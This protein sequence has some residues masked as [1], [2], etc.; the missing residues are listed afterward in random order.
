MPLESSLTDLEREQARLREEIE[1]LKQEY[2]SL[3]QQQSGQNRDG[4]KKEQGDVKPDGDKQD[5]DKKQEPPKPPLRTR[6]RSWVQ[7]HPL[8]TAALAVAFVA[9]LIGAFVFWRYLSSYESTDDAEVDGHTDELSSRIAGVVVGVYVENAQSVHAGQVLVDLDPSDYRVALAQA[10]ANLSAAVTGA[11]QQSRNV[12]ITQTTQST[13]IS[14]RQLDVA[15][16]QAALAAAQRN[17]EGAVADLEQA[18][19]A[20]AYAASEER[21]YAQL[22][23]QLE[24]SREMYD[25]RVTNAQSAAAVVRN[26]QAAADAAKRAVEQQQAVVDRTQEL[27]KETAE[28]SPLQVEMQRDQLETRQ[29]SARQAREA[30]K[31]AQ[32][33]LSYCK[34]IAPADGIIG[35]RSAEVGMQIAPGQELLALTQI[36][37]LWVTANYKETE[38]RQMHAGQSATI[39][40][41]ALGKDFNGYVENLPGA[42][43]A[44]YSLLPPENATG[45][46]VKVVQRMPVRL[47]FKPGQAGA[48]LLRPGMSVEPKVWVR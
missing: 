2:D 21:R 26:R 14:T 7:T 33:N 19:A 11:Q 29:A 30:L 10:Q 1:R 42:T 47:R 28:N 8:A 13:A 38:V 36:N 39:H 46:Y 45:N 25:Q 6:V 43:G 31:Q 17:Y 37:D 5:D 44:V 24:V 15:A 27:A 23:D 40:V 22:V 9:V 18:Q 48:E 20:S 3:K 16:Q 41:D 4:N 35:N 32:L 34:V 12:P